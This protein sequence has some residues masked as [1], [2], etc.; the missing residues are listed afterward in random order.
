MAKVEVDIK[1]ALN[2]DKFLGRVKRNRIALVGIE[3]E[4]GWKKLPD[5]I[6]LT[7]DGSLTGL[8]EQDHPTRDEL[9]AARRGSKQ[10]HI[11]ELQSEPLE[12][13]KLTA[14]MKQYYPN[15]MNETCGL[16]VHMSF[17][18]AKHYMQLMV[19][20]YTATIVEYIGRWAE[21]E[22]LDHKH[23]IWKRLA[24]ENEH[25]KHLFYADIQAKA[26]K[27]DY[28]HDYPGN[29]YTCINYC[30]GL[31]STLECRLLCMMETYEQGV[32]AVQNIL[33]ITNS[34]LIVTAKREEKLKAELQLSAGDYVYVD[35]RL[36][37]V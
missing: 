29:R 8:G 6:N 37:R 36:E 5:G 35:R 28:S 15:H 22:H 11:G 33:D 2:I 14:W 21:R 13:V 16:H 31:H 4:G 26:T 18:R 7:H 32:R 25:C 27:K 10:L 30:N 34:F 9:E 19:P 17:H 1:T 24:G 23:P 20:E 3:L 12:P